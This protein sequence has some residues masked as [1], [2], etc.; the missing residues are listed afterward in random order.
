MD[1]YGKYEVYGLLK[2]GDFN[3]SF[4]VFSAREKI[5][6]GVLLEFEESMPHR[7]KGVGMLDAAAPAESAKR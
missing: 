1:Q 5:W 3:Y 2:L 6:R 7:I 4:L